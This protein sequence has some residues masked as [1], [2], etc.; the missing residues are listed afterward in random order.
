MSWI[1]IHITKGKWA[2]SAIKEEVSRR[3]I[4]ILLF[5]LLVVC[6]FLLT[7][8]PNWCICND[9]EGKNRIMLVLTKVC[10]HVME[11]RAHSN[12]VTII[13][14]VF[15]LSH[16]F[17]LLH[18]FRHYPYTAIIADPRPT[19]TNTYSDSLLLHSHHHRHYIDL[20]IS[21]EARINQKKHSSI[22]VLKLHQ[23]FKKR[24]R[25]SRNTKFKTWITA[26]WTYGLY[27]FEWDQLRDTYIIWLY[28]L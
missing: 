13:F 20:L 22:K 1:E 16:F 12:I 11:C 19:S 14:L 4:L 18:G 26:Y 9:G 23:V 6:Y 24:A 10:L 7:S 28:T 25:K 3:N 2:I 17:S 27:Q 21:F 5:Y 15:V 8:Q